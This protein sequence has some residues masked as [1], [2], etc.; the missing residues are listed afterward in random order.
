MTATAKFPVL[1]SDD[2]PSLEELNAH[3]LAVIAENVSVIAKSLD[4]F[5]DGGA[6]ATGRAT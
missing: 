6:S 5:F 2:E 3:N 1:R 4:G